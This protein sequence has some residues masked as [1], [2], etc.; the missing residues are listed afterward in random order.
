MIE[1]INREWTE[2]QG[3]QWDEID[4]VGREYG[5][6]RGIKI[7]KL[8]KEEDE[9]WAKQVRPLLDDYVKETK[10]KGLPG[11]EALEFCI[12]YLKANRR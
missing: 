1:E 12:N 6:K 11:D 5:G 2:K 7:I 9:R 4:N 8:S 10:Q 3:R